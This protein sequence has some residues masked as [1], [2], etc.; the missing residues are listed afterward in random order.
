MPANIPCA[1]M[2]FV[3]NDFYS[4]SIIKWPE[5]FPAFFFG[6]FA[7]IFKGFLIFL[8]VLH[9]DFLC[10]QLF[11]TAFLQIQNEPADP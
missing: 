10:L 1:K 5:P 6:L 11:A 9:M 7:F 4:A 2:R 8:T 3:Q